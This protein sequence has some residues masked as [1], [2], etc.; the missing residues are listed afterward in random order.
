MA[1]AAVL[2][3]DSWPAG[4]VAAREGRCALAGPNDWP[5]AIE[6]LIADPARA[7]APAQANAEALRRPDPAASQ[8]A[9]WD[10]LLGTGGGNAPR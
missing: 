10:D 1:G 7:R 6:R 2:A 4:V 8:R 9:L 3:S 5:A